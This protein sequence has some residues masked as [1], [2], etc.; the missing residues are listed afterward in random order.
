MASDLKKWFRGIMLSNEVMNK[1]ICIIPENVGIQV[2]S[3]T[4]IPVFVGFFGVFKLI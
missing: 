3:E 4:W 1:F 2:E